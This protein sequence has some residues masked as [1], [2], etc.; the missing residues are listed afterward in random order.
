MSCGDECVNPAT[1]RAH[2]GECDE[3]CADDRTCRGGSCVCGEGA[4]E[5]DGKCLD[6]RNDPSNCG[7]PGR[8]CDPG[9][10]CSGGSCVA[11][12]ET[13]CNDGED[14]DGDGA[15]DCA[16]TDCEGATRPCEEATCGDGVETCE[17]GG[18][19]SACEGGEGGEEICGD[20]IDQ[21]CDGEDLRD[22][23]VFEPNDTCGSCM[24]VGGTDPAELV[25]DASFDSVDD[26]ID[27]YFFQ[28]E[29]DLNFGLR[30]FVELSL[31]GIPEGHDYDIALY[32]GQAACEA[33]EPIARGVAPGNADEQVRWGETFGED[34]TGAFYVR[35]IRFRGHSCTE[36]YTLTID[37]LR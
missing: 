29:D 36:G 12:R 37:G 17:P 18:T 8:Q 20:G 16:D 9:Q 4:T 6:T 3:S 2:C 25:L 22:P 31:T 21:D 33:D 28:A 5:Q 35:V 7:I 10:V 30:E 1:D 26:P 15:E 13:A 11:E 23:D 32:R 14:D 27:C 19:W 24:R 34:E